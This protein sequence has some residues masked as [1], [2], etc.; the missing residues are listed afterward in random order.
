MLLDARNSGLF[1]Q[2]EKGRLQQVLE[3]KKAA[4]DMLAATEARQRR[5][6]KEYAFNTQLALGA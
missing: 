6:Q 5:L 3:R 1:M 2:E 4:E